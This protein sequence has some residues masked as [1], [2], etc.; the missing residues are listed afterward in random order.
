MYRCALLF[1]ALA[2]SLTSANGQGVTNGGPAKPESGKSGTS[3]TASA[4]DKKALEDYV[5]HLFVWGPQ[6]AVKIADPKPSQAL[7]GFR[8]ISVVASAGQATQETTFYISPDGTKIVQGNVFD[9]SKNPFE[10]DLSK[11]KTDL[12]PSF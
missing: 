3:T 1:A 4:L 2:L 11:I 7:P 9:L 8:E 12:Q 6:I 5:R 10:S